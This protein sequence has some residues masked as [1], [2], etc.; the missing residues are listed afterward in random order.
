MTDKKSENEK[1][2]TVEKSTNNKDIERTFLL[3]DNVSNNTIKD[4]LINIIKINKHDEEEEKR[5]NNYIRKPI[6]IIISTFGGNIYDG[7]DLVSV[8]D[9]S[10]TPVHTHCY[11]KAMSMGF[12]IFAIGH[13]RFAHPLA[14][15]MY[16]NGSQ[17]I[18]SDYKELEYTVEQGKKMVS[19]IDK[20]ITELTNI[21]QEQLDYYKDR[22]QDWYMFADEAYNLGLVD[23]LLETKRNKYNKEVI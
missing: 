19:V 22:R 2:N 4:I 18:H 15:F 7:F 13:K 3:N 12:L 1:D 8:I 11:G 17:G 21:T 23:V 20:Y 6:N 10:T 5:D 9:T 16:H 14:T